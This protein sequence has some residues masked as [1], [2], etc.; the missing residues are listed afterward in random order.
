MAEGK[1]E[2]GHINV[3]EMVE[4]LG[5]KQNLV[6]TALN[7]ISKEKGH[8]NVG[9]SGDEV[10]VWMRGL[11]KDDCERG[12]K[13]VKQGTAKIA[14]WFEGNID[15]FEP[16]EGGK[17]LPIKSNYKVQVRFSARILVLLWQH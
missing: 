14:K 4:I 1:I 17:K 5:H 12:D 3:N 8:T 9:I 11:Y 13:L 16:D 6:K 10:C 7:K 15:F 2:R